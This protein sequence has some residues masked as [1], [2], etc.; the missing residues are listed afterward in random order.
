MPRTIQTTI[1][2]VPT[3]RRV[4]QLEQLLNVSRS[5]AVGVTVMSWAWLEA[6]QTEGVVPGAPS[7]LD[8]VVDIAGAGQA[9]VDAGLVGVSP[10]G[11][12][13]PIELRR[14]ADHAAGRDESPEARKRRRDR[15]RKAKSRRNQRLTKPASKASPAPVAADVVPKR[16]PRK[17]GDI[18]GFPVM[19]LFR[20][21]DGCPFYKLEGASPKQWTATVTDP[22]RPSFAEAVTGLHAAMKRGQGLTESS[23]MRPTPEAVML[24]AKRYQEQREAAAAVAARR[25]EANNAL[26]EAAADDQDNDENC[27]MSAP[28]HACPRDTVTCPPPCPP[29][30]HTAVV[31]SPYGRH[32]LDADLCHTLCPPSGHNLPL[33]SSSSS[34]C[35]SSEDKSKQITTTTKPQA[36]AER[37]HEADILD[38]LCPREDPEQTRQREQQR[39]LLE[40]YAAAL[41]TTADA[42]EY[43]MRHAREVL[44][45]RLKAAGI[46][47]RTGLR[48]GAT[49]EPAGARADIGTT[50]EPSA[51]GEPAESVVGARDAD[52]RNYDT[53]SRYG[54]M[55]QAEGTLT[56]AAQLGA[57]VTTK[58]VDDF[59]DADESN[60]VL[61]SQ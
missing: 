7:M 4:L 47:P 17:L 9:L 3:D 59:D 40:R 20:R 12:V 29:S 46:D 49:D 10:D 51:T 27:D 14:H 54:R 53:L 48:P 24:A 58:S 52:D 42:V 37:D 8:I 41:G 56:A 31:V 44:L 45:T 25:D 57:V 16:M 38:R 43:Q 60:T 61:T 2:P 19:L 6:E 1:A 35:I 30:G 15:E 18:D 34:S 28:G 33:S 39:Q 36:V 13:L 55:S 32:D 23:A 21:D 50:T 11:I 22:E 26:L 5:Q